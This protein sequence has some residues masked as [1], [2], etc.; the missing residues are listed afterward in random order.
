M[1]VVP[2]VYRVLAQGQTLHQELCV[3]TSQ[4]PPPRSPIIHSFHR[5]LWELHPCRWWLQNPRGTQPPLPGIQ[6]RKGVNICKQ[7]DERGKNIWGG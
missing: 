3:H 5:Y 6:W 7:T 4:N 1:T 2:T